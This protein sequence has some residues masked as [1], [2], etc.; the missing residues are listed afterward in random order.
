ML[1]NLFIYSDYN[2]STTIFPIPSNESLPTSTDTSFSTESTA[3]NIILGIDTPILPTNLTIINMSQYLYNGTAIPSEISQSSEIFSNTSN[4]TATVMPIVM[5]YSINRS[6]KVDETVS[7]PVLENSTMDNS[8]RSFS[9][10]LN[11]TAHVDSNMLEHTT[12]V[13]NELTPDMVQPRTLRIRGVKPRN[14]T[15]EKYKTTKRYQRRN[16]TKT[17]I[18]NSSGKK[19]NLS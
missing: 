7:S 8:W 17:T 15:S 16:Q 4:S 6:P 19:N 14:I 9:L 11:L 10:D 18:K 13:I 3:P 1:L 12:S 2:I 5:L